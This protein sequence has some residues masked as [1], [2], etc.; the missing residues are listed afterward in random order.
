MDSNCTT[1]HGSKKAYGKSPRKNQMGLSAVVLED[2]NVSGMMKN[3][4]IARSIAD[5]GFFE[6]RRQ[7]EYYDGWYGSEVMFANRFYPSSKTCLRCGLELSR[8]ERVF[9]CNVCGLKTDRDG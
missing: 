2:L 1:Q 6:F 3:H 9:R 8:G 5:V 4:C 7:L